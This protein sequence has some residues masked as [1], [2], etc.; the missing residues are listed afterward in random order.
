MAKSIKMTEENVKLMS[1]NQSKVEFS[2]QIQT[3]LEDE[4]FTDVTFVCDDQNQLNAHKLVLSGSSPFL[5]DILLHNTDH[6]STICMPGTKEKVIR[7]VL[8]YLYTGEVMIAKEG[9]D[10]FMT[11]AKL[12]GL[13]VS[14]FSEYNNGVDS[15]ETVSVLEKTYQLSIEADIV[16]KEITEQHTDGRNS[17]DE[18]SLFYTN[19]T[20]LDSKVEI[21]LSNVDDSECVDEKFHCEECNKYYTARK[22]LVRHKRIFHEGK[23]LSCDKCN[24]QTKRKDLLKAHKQSQH[25]H[26]R[27]YC[28]I[29]VYSATQQSNVKIHQQAEH[30]GVKYDCNECDYQTTKQRQLKLHKVSK[31]EGLRYSC[32]ECEFR[33][34]QQKT[35]KSHKESKHE[36]IRYSCEQCNY[37][38]TSK[39]HL[40]SHQQIKHEGLGYSCDQCDY[41][42][43][44]DYNLKTHIKNAHLDKMYS[45]KMFSCDKCNFQAKHQKTLKSHNE[46][47]H[48]G[49]SYPCEQCE[50]KGSSKSLVVSHQK[51]V[52]EGIRYNCEQCDYQ[53]TRPDSLKTHVKK[54]N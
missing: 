32:N 42:A 35:L 20:L 40:I 31:H 19:M 1:N 43:T 6:I 34:I 48:E 51:S 8:H 12:F 21:S 7:E 15:D 9:V 49:I 17:E 30:E 24:Y 5:A 52:H 41:Q 54:H 39:V 33:A 50:Y 3:F 45:E 18:N 4:R 2:S 26:V 16:K 29:C 22:V 14:L 53:A 25:D 44:Q 36:G 11:A 10:D 13:T 27:Y 23:S 28:N 37:K 46:F 38:G 47:K